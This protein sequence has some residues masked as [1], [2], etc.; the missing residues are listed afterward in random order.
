M[1]S[2]LYQV[3][4]SLDMGISLVEVAVVVM[5]VPSDTT[6]LTS[7]HQ[8]TGVQ[9]QEHTPTMQA[10]EQALKLRKQYNT[11]QFK[12]QV[13]MCFLSGTLIDMLPAAGL[14]SIK[15]VVVGK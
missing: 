5:L 2:L 6:A 12:L 3:E 7:V 8:K 14:A 9:E 1:T 11:N 4:H 13:F 10:L 15:E